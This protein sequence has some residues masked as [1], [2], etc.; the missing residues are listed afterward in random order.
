MKGS[1]PCLASC[2]HRT[3]SQLSA[4]RFLGEK[5]YL[6]VAVCGSGATRAKPSVVGNSALGQLEA[7]CGRTAKDAVAPWARYQLIGLFAPFHTASKYQS[8]HDSTCKLVLHGDR[9]KVSV[10]NS[11]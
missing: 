4:I 9:G 5:E 1:L 10:L 6:V 7:P 2:R 3:S 11:L 8:M